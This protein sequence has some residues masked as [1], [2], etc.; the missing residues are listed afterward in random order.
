MKIRITAR[1]NP[2]TG[3]PEIEDTLYYPD[4]GPIPPLIEPTIQ[5]RPKTPEQEEKEKK[6]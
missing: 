6:N 3:K 2:K 5:K 1:I 4:S